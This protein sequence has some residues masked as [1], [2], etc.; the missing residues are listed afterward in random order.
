MEKCALKLKALCL[1]IRLKERGQ[2]F[3]FFSSKDTTQEMNGKTQTGKILAKHIAN[4]G[5][6]CGIYEV[7]QLNNR[8]L[9][10]SIKYG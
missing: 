4:R 9:S 8:M 10:H 2:A 3:S 7:L 6:V 1:K 5:L